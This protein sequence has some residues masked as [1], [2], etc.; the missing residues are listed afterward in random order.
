MKTVIPLTPFLLA[1]TLCLLPACTTPAKTGAALTECDG[2]GCE[3][4][5]IMDK[6]TP[7]E[8]E[9]PACDNDGPE[10][11]PDPVCDEPDCNDPEPE[12]APEC[13]TLSENECAQQDNFCNPRYGSSCP[14][15]NDYVYQGCSAN[16]L[17]HSDPCLSLDADSCTNDDDLCEPYFGS[18]C[19]GCRDHI[20][21]GCTTQGL[22]SCELFDP[23]MCDFHSDDCEGAYYSECDDCE[24]DCGDCEDVFVCWPR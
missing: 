1:L 19:P 12:L 18:S 21:W 9:E 2:E 10:C 15:C 16:T 14:L 22:P 8:G 13:E 23:E 3:D 11:M 5:G 7:S 20:Y 24:G 4:P 17:S 6:E